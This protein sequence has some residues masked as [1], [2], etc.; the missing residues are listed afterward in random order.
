[1]TKDSWSYIQPLS[2]EMM[3]GPALGIVYLEEQKGFGSCRQRTLHQTGE[4]DIEHTRI[5]INVLF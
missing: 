4:T 1:M 5:L 2:G 3:V